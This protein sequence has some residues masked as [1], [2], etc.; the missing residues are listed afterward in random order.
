MKT[1][2]EKIGSLCADEFSK[3][4]NSPEQLSSMLET[5]SKSIGTTLAFACRGNP[6]HINEMMQGVENYIMEVAVSQSKIAKAAM[7]P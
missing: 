2:D 5:L 3:N 1:F 7:K 4:L 6:K